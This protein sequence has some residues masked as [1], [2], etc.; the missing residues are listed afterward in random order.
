MQHGSNFCIAEATEDIED[1][2]DSFA[3]MHRLTMLH[4][5]MRSAHCAALGYT[6]AIHNE[7]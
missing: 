1:H 5:S 2:L 6:S 4:S 7:L 3:S